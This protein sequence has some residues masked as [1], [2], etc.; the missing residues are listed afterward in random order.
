MEEILNTRFDQAEWLKWLKWLNNEPKRFEE[1]MEIALSDLKPQA[2]RAAWLLS[3]SNAFQ[4]SKIKRYVNPILQIISLREDGHQR[5]L[6]KLI[7]GVKLTETQESKL[8]DCCLTIYENISKQS[9]VRY[10]AFYNLVRIAKNYPE[11]KNELHHLTESHY[12]ESL[13]PGI[14]RSFEKLVDKNF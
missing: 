12:T 7:E 3:K 4:P 6:L 14:K 8:L 2:W 9:S 1:A 11:L 10:T 5:T 13:S